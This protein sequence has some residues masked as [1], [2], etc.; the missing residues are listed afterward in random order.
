MAF[1]EPVPGEKRPINEVSLP[2]SNTS[3]PTNEP[4]ALY[5]AKE[6]QIQ[7]DTPLQQIHFAYIVVQNDAGFI[8]IHQQNAHE[9]ILYERFLKAVDGKPIAIQQSLFP[10]NDGTAALMW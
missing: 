4:A 10:Q 7:E 5:A 2:A 1:Y 8:V 9:R 6:Q 3:A